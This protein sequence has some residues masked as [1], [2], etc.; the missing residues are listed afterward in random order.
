[1]LVTEK[2]ITLYLTADN[3][4]IATIKQES[5]INGAVFTDVG[6]TNDSGN[7]SRIVC[8]TENKTIQMY[9]LQGSLVRLNYIGDN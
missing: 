4:V 5:R 7:Q 2:E 3:S 6:K 1:M 9:N 8:I